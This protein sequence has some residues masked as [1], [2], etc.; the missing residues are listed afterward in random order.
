MDL[1][2]RYNQ[3]GGKWEFKENMERR[4][5]GGKRQ[6]EWKSRRK[7][8]REKQGGKEEKSGNEKREMKKGEIKEE[9]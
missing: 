4:S 3:T 2:A 6:E 5:Q 8:V 1:S 7:E 9:D